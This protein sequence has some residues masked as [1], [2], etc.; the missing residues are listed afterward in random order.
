MWAGS[1]RPAEIINEGE[2]TCVP[3]WAGILPFFSFG[4]KYHH[5]GSVCDASD[6]PQRLETVMR[7]CQESLQSLC[8]KLEGPYCQAKEERMALKTAMEES[9]P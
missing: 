3:A 6:F 2:V 4:G 8:Y 9:L 1:G 5:P 7:K